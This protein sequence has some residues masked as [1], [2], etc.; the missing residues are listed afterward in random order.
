MAKK[1]LDLLNGKHRGL[2]LGIFFI[3]LGALFLHPVGGD[4]DYYHHLNAGKDILATHHLPHLDT[5]TFTANGKEWVGH[6]W[7]SSVTFYLLDITIGPLG[8]SVF[9]AALA[10]LTLLLLYSWLKGYNFSN[11]VV[12]PL[13]LL[14]AGVFSLR[15]PSRPE[16]L[17]YP[18]FLTLFLI[19]Q[20]RERYPRLVYLSPVV[21]F[22]WTN[23]YGAGV[24]VGVSLL[25]LFVAKQFILDRFTVARAQVSFYVTSVVAIVLSCLNGYGFKSLFYLFYIHEMTKTEMEWYGVIKLFSN[26]SYS[27]ML[28]VQ[29][30]IL[31]YFLIVGFF[32]T[33]VIKARKKIIQFK[34]E[35]ILAVGI[36]VPLYAFRQFALA[37]IVIMPLVASLIMALSEQTRRTFLRLLLG[38]ASFSILI[39]L[40][41]DFPRFARPEGYPADLISFIQ[42]HGL[43]GNI[44]NQPQDGGY[45][46]YN[47]Y[48]DGKVYAD[49]RDELYKGT[50]VYQD[51]YQSMG[52]MKLEN[53]LGKYDVDI[54]VGDLS[55]GPVFQPLFNSE[56]WKPVYL[57]GRYFVALPTDVVK[58]KGLEPLSYADPYLP[59][60][61]KK[62]FEEEAL[63][64]YGEKAKD[65][66]ASVDDK[67]RYA[68]VLFFQ[69]KYPEA[70]DELKGIESSRNPRNV[71]FNMGKDY[72]T[73]MV[74]LNK[75][76][77]FHADEYLSEMNQGIKSIMLFTPSKKL[78]PLEERGRKIFKNSCGSAID[79]FRQG[80]SLRS[81]Y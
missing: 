20:A 29:Y 30:H 24:I 34:F 9:V 25:C 38:L 1:L 77:C 12:L 39:S 37:C 36:L 17:V 57:R 72:L 69:K 41:L 65:D 3:L 62:G 68:Y 60:A 35:A 15:W 79:N 26:A 21:I 23:F 63:Q 47:L 42:E 40:Y 80:S 51:F 54:I 5:Y 61:T 48:P 19:E 58:E 53:L 45:L 73:A 10:V 52:E 75:K 67:L 71:L 44:L 74:Y 81:A 16:I 22:A 78:P 2:F 46:S 6:S 33:L 28:S 64:R 59:S 11:S 43:K 32:A 66:K 8:T 7:L 49:T 70:L 13:V 27:Y 14:A 76:D 50:T 55:L 31:I 56:D 4:G 18:F